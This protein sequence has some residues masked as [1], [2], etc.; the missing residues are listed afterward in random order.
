MF[1]GNLPAIVSEWVAL[2]SLASSSKNEALHL[3]VKTEIENLLESM[4]RLS[5]KREALKQEMPV[6]PKPSL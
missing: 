5:E 3:R 1:I 2:G 6:A 4:E